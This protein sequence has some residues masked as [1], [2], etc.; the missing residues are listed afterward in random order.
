MTAVG[1][2]W[3]EGPAARH[4]HTPGKSS[5]GRMGCVCEACHQDL[6]SEGNWGDVGEKT[7]GWLQ[8]PPLKTSKPDSLHTNLLTRDLL[9]RG[10]SD[11]AG[12]TGCES[13]FRHLGMLTVGRREAGWVGGGGAEMQGKSM[14]GQHWVR[15]TSR[16]QRSNMSHLSWP[17]VQV[18]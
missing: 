8:K 7:P 16:P 4:W 3:R 17:L 15:L 14:K 2:P 12:P 1:L 18:F 5:R 11:Q 10:R 6:L 13:G 9:S